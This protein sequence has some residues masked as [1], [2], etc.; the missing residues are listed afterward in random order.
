MTILGAKLVI[1]YSNLF[2]YYEQDMEN[3]N[4]ISYY[5]NNVYQGWYEN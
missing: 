1:K 2:T 5:Y 4:K 3:K